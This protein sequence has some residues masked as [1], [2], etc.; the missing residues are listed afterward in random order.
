MEYGS[1][2]SYRPSAV[3]YTRGTLLLT[4]QS[5]SQGIVSA[6]WLNSPIVISVILPPDEDG[7]VSAADSVQVRDVDHRLVHRHSAEHG[8]APAVDQDLR[9]VARSRVSP[10]A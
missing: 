9:P 2:G 10:S 1:Y 6:H 7:L 3:L 5:V 8:A 4:E